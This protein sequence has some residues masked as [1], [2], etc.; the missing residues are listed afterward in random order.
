MEYF[1]VGIIVALALLASLS[2]IRGWLDLK[3]QGGCG[4][5]CD[6]D[7]SA[8]CGPEAPEKGCCSSELNGPGP[9]LDCHCHEDETVLSPGETA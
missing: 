9:C 8:E 3:K 1:V 2:R 4:S 5:G 7:C 6:C